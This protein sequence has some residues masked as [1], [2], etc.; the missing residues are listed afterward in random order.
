M[1]LLGPSFPELDGIFLLHCD[2][3]LPLN[4]PIFIKLLILICF[5]VVYLLQTIGNL[6]H[7]L[8]YGVFQSFP[9]HFV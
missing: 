3:V 4:I 9:Y 6:K 7:L 2:Y 8:A 5:V 1:Y